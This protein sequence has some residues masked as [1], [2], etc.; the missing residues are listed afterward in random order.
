MRGGIVRTIAIVVLGG[1]LGGCEILPNDGYAKVSYR[2]R[3][4]L[5]PA[6]TPAPP[7]LAA[8]YSVGGGAAATVPDLPA[9]APAGVTQ[10]MVVAGAE[11]FGTVCAACHGAAGVGTAAAPALTDTN[12][13][14][15]GGTF[16]EIV[17]IIHS[18]VPNPTESPAPMPPLGGGNF[19]DDQVR[20]LAAYVFALSHQAP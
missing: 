12:W 13:L 16:D 15:I 5:P 11:Q 9:T 18:G 10:D 19:N 7:P 1:A 20:Q 17:A 2:V 4:P 3:D 8:G 14:H 6:A